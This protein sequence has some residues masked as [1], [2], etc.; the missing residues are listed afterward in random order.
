MAITNDT[1]SYKGNLPGGSGQRNFH[2][3]CLLFGT[4]DYPF[5][6]QPISTYRRF[7]ETE[8]EHFSYSVENGIPPQGRWK[9]SG[10]HIPIEF[11]SVLYSVN[12]ERLLQF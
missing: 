12:A 5:N 6:F 7:I 1:K 9:I 2:P 11:K 8:D 4:D 3:L 10:S